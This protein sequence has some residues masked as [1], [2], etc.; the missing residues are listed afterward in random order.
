[1]RCHAESENAI[2]QTNVTVSCVQEFID[3]S[4]SIILSLLSAPIASL[5]SLFSLQTKPLLVEGNSEIHTLLPK[6][7]LMIF[8]T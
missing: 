3:S 4:I 1:M 5:V 8:Q 7:C 6:I 2:L